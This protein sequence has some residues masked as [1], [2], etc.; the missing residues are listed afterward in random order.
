MICFFKFCRDKS[1]QEIILCGHF[2][3][4]YNEFPFASAGPT[5][6]KYCAGTARVG[7]QSGSWWASW[8]TSSGSRSPTPSAEC[9]EPPGIIISLIVK[10]VTWF[11]SSRTE[12]TSFDLNVHTLKKHMCWKQDSAEHLIFKS[13]CAFIQEQAGVAKSAYVQAAPCPWWLWY[14]QSIQLQT[15]GNE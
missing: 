2:T 4:R 13:L 3:H 12:M 10:L 9:V 1:L 7:M 5:Y 6:T 14:H 15:A 8:P 11:Y